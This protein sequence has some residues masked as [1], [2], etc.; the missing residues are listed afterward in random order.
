MAT[1][2]LKKLQ[3]PQKQLQPAKKPKNDLT[4]NAAK[5][6]RVPRK[7]KREANTQDDEDS[8]RLKVTSTLPAKRL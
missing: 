6:A 2:Q 5:P 8:L 7:P 3:A 4:P 1:L